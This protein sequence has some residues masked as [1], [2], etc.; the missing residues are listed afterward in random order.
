MFVGGSVP[1]YQ[2]ELIFWPFTYFGSFGQPGIPVMYFTCESQK[3]KKHNEWL[4]TD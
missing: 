2:N 4:E 3:I 1:S